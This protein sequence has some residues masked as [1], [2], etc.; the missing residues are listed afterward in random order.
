MLLRYPIVSYFILSFAIA[1]SV[2]I[3]VGMLVAEPS[4]ALILPGAWAPTIAAVMLTA[5]T[6]GRSG[7]QGYV[8][9]S[10][11]FLAVR[12]SPSSLSAF[13]SFWAAPRQQL[14]PLPLDSAYPQNALIR[15]LLC[16]L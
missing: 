16:F 7:V 2:W 3:P 14:R 11:P 13:T 10:L 15:S 9:T 1:W 8:G 12:L 4:V 5:V 6:E